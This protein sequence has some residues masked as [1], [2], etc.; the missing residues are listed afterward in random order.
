M[1]VRTF[2]GRPDQVAHAREET[3]KFPG[4]HL[5]ND[6][7]VPVVSELASNAVLHSRS[8]DGEF[9][10]GVE[11]YQSYVYVEVQDEGDP[12]HCPEHDGRPH[13]LDIVTA[14]TGR[15]WG[16]DHHKNGHRAVRARVHFL[17]AA[18]S[19]TFRRTQDGTFP[20]PLP[21]VSPFSAPAFPARQ[22]LRAWRR[23]AIPL[24]A[25]LMS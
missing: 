2:P 18:P 11:V 22:A 17:A 15:D 25:Q 6:D 3:R 10:I 4:G 20:V 7:A 14:L 21:R 9:A 1:L 19:G 13:G 5:A 24:A 23:E 12:W 16:V 8:S